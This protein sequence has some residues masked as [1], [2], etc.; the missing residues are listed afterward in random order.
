M[1]LLKKSLLTLRCDFS[2]AKDSDRPT[3]V[4]GG[5]L[6]RSIGEFW[7]KMKMNVSHY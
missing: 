5:L 7:K 2:L 3:V 6:R 1:E 4:V